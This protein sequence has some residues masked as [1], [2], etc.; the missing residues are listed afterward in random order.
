LRIADNIPFALPPKIE[1]IN[2]GR[3]GVMS[4]FT[5]YLIALYEVIV[6]FDSAEQPYI[7]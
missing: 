3:V 1:Q 5:N 7:V 6:I 2:G 4:A